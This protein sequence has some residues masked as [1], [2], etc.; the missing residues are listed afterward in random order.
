MKTLHTPQR[1][2]V[3]LETDEEGR[4]WV[5]AVTFRGR[6]WRTKVTLEIWTYWGEW[7]LDPD[8]KGESRLY[9]VIGTQHGE[10]SLFQR[11][12]GKAEDDGWFVEG[13]FD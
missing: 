3:W 12:G 8:L 6:T 5:C 10:I 9:F 2:Q 11:S 4:P 7:W 1:C 13:W